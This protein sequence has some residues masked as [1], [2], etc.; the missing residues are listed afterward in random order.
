MLPL[1]H[2]KDAAF[3]SE[4]LGKG[5][6]IY[7]TEGKPYAPVNG[8]ISTLFPTGHAI[9]LISE[10]GAEILVHVGLDTVQLEGKYFTPIVKQGDEVKAGDLLLEFDIEGFTKSGYEI[11]TPIVVTNSHDF[12]DVIGIE[13]GDVRAG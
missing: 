3:S 4:A 11:L 6:A 9:G 7:P 13:E 2:V 8:T 10:D 12:L 5:V 1:S